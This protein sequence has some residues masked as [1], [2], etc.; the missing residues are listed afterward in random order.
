MPTVGS[1]VAVGSPESHAVV[2][3]CAFMS[4]DSGLVGESF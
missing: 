4:R 2:F 1:H 3:S